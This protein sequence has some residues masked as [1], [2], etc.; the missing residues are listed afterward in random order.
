MFETKISKLLQTDYLCPMFKF[1]PSDALE[2]LEIDKVID[3]VCK[4]CYA[5]VS[6]RNFQQ[7]PYFAEI[8]ELER[9]LILVDSCMTAMQ[10]GKILPLQSFQDL[11]Y[12]FKMLSKEDFTLSLNDLFQVSKIIHLTNDV[13]NFFNDEIKEVYPLLWDEIQNFPSPLPLHVQME[14]H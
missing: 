2:R 3:L 13:F 11:E 10:R 9:Q 1:Y 6:E 7:Q 14:M 4:H 8:E 12:T 5:A